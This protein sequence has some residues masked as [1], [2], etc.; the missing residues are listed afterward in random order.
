MVFSSPIFLFLFLPAVLGLYFAL[1]RSAWNV[2]LLL[3]SLVFYA[4]GETR[5]TPVLLAWIAINWFYGLWI[6]GRRGERGAG[7]VM[8]IAVGTNVAFL[9][10]FKYANLVA[11]GVNDVVMALGSS[12][13]IELSPIALPLGISFLTFHALSYLI[14]VARGAR[15]QRNPLNLALYLMLFPQLVAG[16]IVRY[17]HLSP[18]I[19]RRDVGLDDFAAGVRRF[20]VGLG[21]KVLIA[22]RLATPADAIFAIAPGDL[23]LGLTW[24]GAAYYTLQIY[25]DFSGYSDMAIGLGRMLGFRFLENFEYPYTARS[26]REFWQRWHIS[27]STWFRDYV[28]IPLGGNRRSQGRVYANLVLVFALCGLW[29][30]ARWTFLVWG[31]YHGAFLVLER[32]RFG[33]LLERSPAALRH[34]Y[35]L[36]VVMVGWVLF[37]AEGFTYATEFLSAMI[38]LG[39]GTGIAYHPGLYVDPAVVL[40]AA[41]G[42]VGSLPLVQALDRWRER[43]APPRFA[44]ATDVASV[45]VLA[46][47]LV[48]SCMALAAGTYNPFIY[49][50][51]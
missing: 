22:N 24:L 45:A 2:F 25:F 11:D 31:L 17:A 4:W 49:Y 27:L 33:N 32:G 36:L 16:P 6:D 23:T 26:V 18:Q 43:A 41:V 39:R 8:A 12:P 9:V 47:V 40:A 15:A 10:V 28:Y 44:W 34:V 20:I 35:L 37:R 14:D 46:L 5:F 29:H 50:R 48:V 13:V 21:K 7:F 1:P 51:F 30:G 38:G 42:I 3:A 19:A